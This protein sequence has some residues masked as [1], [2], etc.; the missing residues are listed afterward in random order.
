MNRAI[1]DYFR[2][3]ELIIVGMVDRIDRFAD[4]LYLH[5]AMLFLNVARRILES[6]HRLFLK[7]VE[8]SDEAY[9]IAREA[10]E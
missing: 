6:E 7:M 10:Y 3:T 4:K 2:N 9:E 8:I 1:A 5:K